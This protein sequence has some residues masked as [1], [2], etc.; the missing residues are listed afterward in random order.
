MI[1]CKN[2]S[3]FS[4]IQ[5]D[6]DDFI[7]LF[8]LSFFLILYFSH[9]FIKSL[10]KSFVILAVFL[11]LDMSCHHIGYLKGLAIAMISGIYLEN[12]YALFYYYLIKYLYNKKKQ[13]NEILENGYIENDHIKDKPD[14]TE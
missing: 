13:I 12:V 8:L 3:T 9:S 6:Y 7:L 1:D 4:L 11:I 10:F 14:E 2:E 5:K